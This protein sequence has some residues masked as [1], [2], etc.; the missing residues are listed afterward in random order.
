MGASYLQNKGLN[1]KIINWL[2]AKRS[3]K[4]KEDGYNKEEEWHNANETFT[5][6]KQEDTLTPRKRKRFESPIPMPSA[7]S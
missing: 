4:S 3:I 1:P 6:V 7:I 2:I 5:A